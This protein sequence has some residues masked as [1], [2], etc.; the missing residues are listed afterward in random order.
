MMM[1][2]KLAICLFKFYNK[3]FNSKE[4]APL[5]FNQILTG[6]QTHFITLKSNSLKVGIQP[7]WLRG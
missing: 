3:D 1:K 7:W 6:S 2:Y 5:N 4:F